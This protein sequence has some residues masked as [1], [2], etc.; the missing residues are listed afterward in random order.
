MSGALIQLVAYGAQD[1]YLKD[2]YANKI[3]RAYLKHF[4]RRKYAAMII[5]R[6]CHNWVWKPECKDGT[7][8]IRPRLDM[9]YLSEYI[10]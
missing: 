8:G 9:E 5:S 1:I 2:T 6:G 10:Y 7:I 3:Q 4:T